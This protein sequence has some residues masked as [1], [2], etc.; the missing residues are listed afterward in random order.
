VKRRDI[1]TGIRVRQGA[2]TGR[3]GAASWSPVLRRLTGFTVIWDHQ[4]GGATHHPAR[5]ARQFT[6]INMWGDDWL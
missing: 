2:F 5:E 1:S 3:I 4:A 6:C